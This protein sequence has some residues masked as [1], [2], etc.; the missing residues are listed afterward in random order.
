MTAG[1]GVTIVNA[2]QVPLTIGGFQFT[3]ESMLPITVVG[4]VVVMLI[5]G[6]RREIAAFAIA[7]GVIGAMM[8]N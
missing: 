8:M 3:P 7:A 5:F 6:V 4:V 2:E 1:T